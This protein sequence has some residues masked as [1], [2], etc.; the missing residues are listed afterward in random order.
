MEIRSDNKTISDDAACS[1]QTGLSSGNLPD[2]TMTAKQGDSYEARFNQ[3]GS[4]PST[5][6]SLYGCEHGL[7]QCTQE[8]LNIDTN[9]NGDNEFAEMVDTEMDAVKQTWKIKNLRTLSTEVLCRAFPNMDP[10]QVAKLYAEQERHRKHSIECLS[11]LCRK[12]ISTLCLRVDID[13]LLLHYAQT[14]VDDAQ[15]TNAVE[16]FDDFLK[17]LAL[18]PVSVTVSRLSTEIV[19]L[20]TKPHWINQDPYSDLEDICSLTRTSSTIGIDDE[21]AQKWI[22]GVNFEFTGGHVLRRRKQMYAT[23]RSRRNN[24]HYS[25]YQDMCEDSTP[26][27]RKP[28]IEWCVGLKTPSKYRLRSQAKIRELNRRKKLGLNVTDRLIHSYPLFK[29]DRSQSSE[30]P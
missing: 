18:K 21:I 13:E 23:E 26:A 14:C 29:P 20:W 30:P 2:I 28:K 19:E 10:L 11:A 8:V 25:F 16:N 12:A 9:T 4:E 27:A 15:S 3:T 17:T 22:T 24:T 1:H 6:A 7:N 5:S